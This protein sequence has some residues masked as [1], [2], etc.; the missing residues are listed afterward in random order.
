MATLNRIPKSPDFKSRCRWLTV[1]HHQQR[2]NRPQNHS[3]EVRM[4]FNI[5][6]PCQ[7]HR[8]RGACGF[9]LTP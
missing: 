9:L 3:P 2:K 5:H 6:S 1:V 4:L 8:D 7:D